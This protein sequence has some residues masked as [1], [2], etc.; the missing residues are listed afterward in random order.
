M[1]AIPLALI[2]AQSEANI[3]RKLHASFF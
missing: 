2:F 1:T 3:N